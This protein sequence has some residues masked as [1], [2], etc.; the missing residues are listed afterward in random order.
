MY[1]AAVTK[2][3]GRN[4]IEKHRF[5]SN[6]SHFRPNCDMFLFHVAWRDTFRK[7]GHLMESNGYFFRHGSGG[8]LAGEGFLKEHLTEFVE[9]GQLLGGDGFKSPHL[10]FQAS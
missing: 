1:R 7:G 6:V 8:E 5:T 4:R 2:Q 9:V 3:F 10:R